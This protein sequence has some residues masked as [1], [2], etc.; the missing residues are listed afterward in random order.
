MKTEEVIKV[1][2]NGEIKKWL[3]SLTKMRLKSNVTSKALE[4]YYDYHKNRKGFLVRIQEMN[5]ELSK[6][7][8]KFLGKHF[9]ENP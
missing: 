6:S 5:F 4:F 7:I 9:K 1:R 2:V 8:N 3:D